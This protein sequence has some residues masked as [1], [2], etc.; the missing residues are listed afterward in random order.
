MSA[1]DAAVVFL[2]VFPCWKP[3]FTLVGITQI[4]KKAEQLC[5]IVS[6]DC[7]E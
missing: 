4:R 7:T 5:F 6:Y 2:V 3:M 1:H